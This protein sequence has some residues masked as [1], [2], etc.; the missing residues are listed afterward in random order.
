MNTVPNLAD[1]YTKVS[2]DAKIFTFTIRQGVYFQPPVNTE[3]TAADVVAS[4][5][6]AANSKNWIAGTPGY[7][8]AP[9]VGTDEHRRRQERPHRRQGARQVDRPGHPQVPVR[10]VP[11]DPRPPDHRGLAG[12]LRHEGRHQDLRPEADRH[13]SLRP[14][15]VGPQPGDRPRQEPALVERERDQRS[16]RR[17]HPHARVHRDLDRV[18][19]LPG[20]QH[21]LHVGAGRPGARRP[22]NIAARRAGSPRSGPSWPSTTS[23]ST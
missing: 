17:R 2:S 6:A 21:R 4:W 3:V 23:T 10:R 7:I 18:A 9:I 20:R 1:Q 16:V 13:R 15:E 19:R 11:G 22:T 12:R 5:N 14:L 8:F